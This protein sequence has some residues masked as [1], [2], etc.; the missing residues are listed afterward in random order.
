MSDSPG[1]AKTIVGTRTAVVIDVL[2]LSFGLPVVIILITLPN[3]IL[4][5]G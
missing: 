4:N 1:L 2:F 3:T 5:G